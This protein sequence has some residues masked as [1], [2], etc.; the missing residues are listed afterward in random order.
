MKMFNHEN[1]SY[2]PQTKKYELYEVEL[3]EDY[4]LKDE[5]GEWVELYPIPKKS[6]DETI[7]KEMNDAFPFKM[8][9]ADE[10]EQM[11]DDF[12]LNFADGE[13]LLGMEY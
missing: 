7:A 5:N 4:Y 12:K 2:N 13:N 6:E 9:T 10:M 8:P 11:F 1:E 3:P